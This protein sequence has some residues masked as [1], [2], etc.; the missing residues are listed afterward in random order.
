MLKAED[1]KG[2]RLGDLRIIGKHKQSNNGGASWI[3]QCS[4]GR[5]TVLSGYD[6]FTR[7]QQ[8][9]GACNYGTY[10]FYDDYA[11]CVLPTGES[12][13]ID[14]EDYCLVSKYRWVSNRSGYFL[15]STGERNSH[16]FLHRMVIEPPDDMFVD[17]IDGNKSNCRKSNL[18][19]CSQTD[20]NRNV[21]VKSNNRCGYK[22]VYWASDRGKWRTEITVDRKHIHIGSFET[23]EEAAR[24]YDKCALFYFGEYA[25]T[26]EMLGLLKDDKQI[27]V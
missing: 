17:H 22:G 5:K 13:I 10:K 24:A 16:V 26:N 9:C 3:C 4:C 19:I 6:L 20:N 25:K 23:A 18:R 11:E 27:A 1:L 15:A 21:G 7:K 8:N 12:F 2:K 14:S